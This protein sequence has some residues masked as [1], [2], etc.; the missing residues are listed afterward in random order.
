MKESVDSFIDDDFAN[1]E[2]IELEFERTSIRL[3][4]DEEEDI[5]WKRKEGSR[6]VSELR[7]YQQHKRRSA[8]LYRDHKRAL[9]TSSRLYTLS[10]LLFDEIR[11]C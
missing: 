5:V 1:R 9:H 8:H 6:R 4:E 3:F 10:L 2:R 7:S 11:T